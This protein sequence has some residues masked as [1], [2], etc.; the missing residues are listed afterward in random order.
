MPCTEG[1]YTDEIG[2]IACKPCPIGQFQD[3]AG[4][5]YCK[6]CPQGRDVALKKHKT[7]FWEFDISFLGSLYLLL[8]FGFIFAHTYMT[9]Y[10][11]KFA[12]VEGQKECSLCPVNTFLDINGQ[13][14]CEACPAG[15]FTVS[16]AGTAGS[17]SGLRSR[18]TFVLK[19]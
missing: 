19:N 8:D 1:S 15:T 7:S 6:D 14:S 2:A 13:S 18:T 5:D 4:Y 17:S 10:S 9:V 16:L 3:K 12:D 11:G